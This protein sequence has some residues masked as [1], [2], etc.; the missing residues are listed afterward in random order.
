MLVDIGLPLRFNSFIFYRLDETIFSSKPNMV[1]CSE[2][3]I[4][5]L[6]FNGASRELTQ[7]A[8]CFRTDDTFS[9]I[10]IRNTSSNITFVNYWATTVNI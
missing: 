10:K 5:G 6:M 9:D 2:F 3:K 1:L 8:T 7:H 4:K